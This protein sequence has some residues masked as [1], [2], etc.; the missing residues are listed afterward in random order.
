MIKTLTMITIEKGLHSEQTIEVCD[1]C[2]EHITNNLNISELEQA[3]WG[4]HQNSVFGKRD[5]PDKTLNVGLYL[6]EDAG[7]ADKYCEICGEDRSHTI[8]SLLHAR[9]HFG[10][11]LK[12]HFRSY[13]LY[14]ECVKLTGMEKTNEVLNRSVK[15]EA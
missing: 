15:K 1:V 4:K 3:P 14:K 7:E 2:F 13:V 12:N 11:I 9:N 5:N 8:E 6:D 10:E